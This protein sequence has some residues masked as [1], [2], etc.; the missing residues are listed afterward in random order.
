[1]DPTLTRWR[2]ARES[3]LE[4][5]YSVLLIKPD[6]QRCLESFVARRI[7]VQFFSVHSSV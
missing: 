7:Y 6:D 2:F 1:M 4:P 5:A 3:D